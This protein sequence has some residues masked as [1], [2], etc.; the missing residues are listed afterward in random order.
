MGSPLCRL[1]FIVTFIASGVR[2]EAAGEIVV[3]RRDPPAKACD[4]RLGNYGGDASEKTE[5]FI[6]K[7]GK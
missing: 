5:I 7:H 4:R 3:P 1:W 2:G 6:W